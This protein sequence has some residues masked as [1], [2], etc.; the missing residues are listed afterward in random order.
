MLNSALLLHD[1]LVEF[2]LDADVV[3]MEAVAVAKKL[4]KKEGTEGVVDKALVGVA[5]VA[6]S[7]ATYVSCP[8]A[9]TQ[10]A[11]SC[12]RTLVDDA[13]LQPLF[14]A[15]PSPPPPRLPARS[16]VCPTCCEVQCP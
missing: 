1:T 13:H 10:F 15:C 2:S 5:Q 8:L 14:V 9:L 12:R 7:L 6:T 16:D 3:A 11:A 4:S